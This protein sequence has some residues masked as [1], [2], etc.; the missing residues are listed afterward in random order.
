MFPLN[1]IAAAEQ[2][3][4]H[5]TAQTIQ[6]IDS[7]PGGDRMV[8]GVRVGSDGQIYKVTGWN[9]GGE[10]YA[11]INSPTDW[12]DIKKNIGNYEAFCSGANADDWDLSDTLGIWINCASQPQW[13]TQRG[14]GGSGTTTGLLTIQIRHA[15][16]TLV[17]ASELYTCNATEL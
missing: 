5:L 1:V 6:S 12:N 11:A 7:A 16:T 4:I 17:K 14:P 9:N 10:D 13:G 3:R 2:E 15:A 8:C